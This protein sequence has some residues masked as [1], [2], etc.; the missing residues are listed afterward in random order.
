[1]RSARLRAVAGA[2]F[3]LI[4]ACAPAA[5]PSPSP[6][7]TAEP[8]PAALVADLAVEGERT[9]HIVCDGPADTGRPTVVFENGSGPTLSTWSA[10]MEDIRATHRVCAYDRAGIGMSGAARGPRTTRDQVND[11]ATLLE[12]A[13]VSG[14]IVLVAHSLGGW[15]A[16][17][18][19]A[20]HPEQVVGAVL[21][22]ITPRGLE[23]RW[24]EELPPETPDEPE[25]IHQAR[26]DFT[27]FLADPS[28]NPEGTN[29]ADSLEQV[30]AAPGFGDRPTEILWATASQLT[31]WPDFPPDLAE[32]L[33]AVVEDLRLDVEALAD[34]PT[35]T[36]VD[37]DHSIHEERPDVVTAAI[38][39]VLDQ[40]EP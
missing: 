5:T 14:P 4:A 33:N 38:R 20:D 17:V 6:S 31:V 29:I 40:L 34:D 16:I 8:T 27:T 39:R 23:R 26:E 18:Y 37:T 28:R 22:D 12:A 11:L 30:L 36:R 25:A 9:L 32:R 10:Q 19:T 24:L 1:M 3:A 35:V 7:P 15:N 13:G 21:V 2:G